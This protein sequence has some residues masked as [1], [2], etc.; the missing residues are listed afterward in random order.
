M[1][2]KAEREKITQIYNDTSD[3]YYYWTRFDKLREPVDGVQSFYQNYGSICFGIVTAT[4]LHAFSNAAL[5]RAPFKSSHYLILGCS[6]WGFLFN[7]IDKNLITVKQLTEEKHKQ[8]LDEKQARLE[9]RKKM[10]ENYQPYDEY[11]KKF[12]NPEEATNV[13]LIPDTSNK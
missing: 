8:L 12:K 3:S 7:Y 9:K 13:I 5:Q 4:V 1:S 10:M 2:S 6:F 11:M